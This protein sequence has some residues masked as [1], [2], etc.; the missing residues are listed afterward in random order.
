MNG[1]QGSRTVVDE[2]QPTERTSLLRRPLADR[3][4]GSDREG[5]QGPELP[6]IDSVVTRLQEEGLPADY[7]WCPEISS[8]T[9]RTAFLLVT[10]LQLQSVAGT[11]TAHTDDTWEEWSREQQNAETLAQTTKHISEIWS[12]FVAEP[13][14][15][16]EL[17]QLLWT[18]FRSSGENSHGLAG[19]LA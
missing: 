1:L 12:Q 19:K 13:R 4:A 7:S 11:Q 5:D 6:P 15:S 14:T 16:E 2:E 9:E 10:L 3:R 17:E 18:R 8:T